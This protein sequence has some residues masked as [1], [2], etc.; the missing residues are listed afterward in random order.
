MGWS[1]E[2]TIVVAIQIPTWPKRL[3]QASL[4]WTR[5]EDSAY[6]RKSDGADGCVAARA[7]IGRESRCRHVIPRFEH[8]GR[9]Y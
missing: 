3:V 5:D 9:R 8:E 6:G 1:E 4:W 7:S 2:L